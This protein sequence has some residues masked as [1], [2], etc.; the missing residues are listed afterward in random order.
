MKTYLLTVPDAANEGAV[1]AALAELLARHLIVL[2]PETSRL[3]DP[4]SEEAF[5][6]ELRAALQSPVLSAEQARAYLGL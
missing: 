5:A 4:M 1:Q 3:F 2:E 6:D